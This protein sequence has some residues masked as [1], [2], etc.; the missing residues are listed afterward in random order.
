M[1]ARVFDIAD[2][3][4]AQKRRADREAAV[5]RQLYAGKPESKRPSL[6]EIMGRSFD[7]WGGAA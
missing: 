6:D 2:W 3:Q 7:P 5:I 1:T 4:A